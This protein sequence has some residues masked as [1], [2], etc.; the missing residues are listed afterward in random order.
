MASRRIRGSRV[1]WRHVMNI[2][3]AIQQLIFHFKRYERTL[4]QGIRSYSLKKVVCRTIMM[5]KYDIESLPFHLENVEQ[6]LLLF[7]YNFKRK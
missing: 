4:C 6:N 1:W 3:I 7:V 5:T 2:A